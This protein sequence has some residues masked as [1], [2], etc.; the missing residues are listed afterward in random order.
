MKIVLGVSIYMQQ[1]TSA[2]DV[3]RCN[4]FVEGEGLRTTCPEEVYSQTCLK[5]AVKG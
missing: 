1:M 4:F 3:F 2:E 5:Q